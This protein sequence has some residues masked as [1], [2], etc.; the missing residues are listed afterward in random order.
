MLTKNVLDEFRNADS[1]EQ[2][3]LK[4]IFSSTKTATG[5]K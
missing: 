2:G 5:Q 1:R 3:R 4:V